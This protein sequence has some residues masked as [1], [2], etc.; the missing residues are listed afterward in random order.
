VDIGYHYQPKWTTWSAETP[1]TIADASDADPTPPTGAS[2]FYKRAFFG[3]PCQ[4]THTTNLFDWGTVLCAYVRS[5]TYQYDPHSNT[6]Y[7]HC[8]IEIKKSLDSGR[9]WQWI[10][11][12][13]CV[14]DPTW[15]DNDDCYL[16][17]R[18]TE[19]WTDVQDNTIQV[20]DPFLIQLSNGDLLCS[21]RQW[22]YG[23]VSY[24]EDGS[25][26]EWED[27]RIR[28]CKL[29][30]DGYNWT[31]PC[32]IQQD[33]PPTCDWG[34][35]FSK[36]SWIV[37]DSTLLERAD[38]KVICFFSRQPNKVV[39][40]VNL[41][42]PVESQEPWPAG[43]DDYLQA[44]PYHWVMPYGAA[45]IITNLDTMSLYPSLESPRQAPIIVCCRPDPVTN[46]WVLG[47]YP[48]NVTGYS[49]PWPL[50]QTGM[51]NGVL[52]S[53]GAVRVVF[54]DTLEDPYT[55]YPLRVSAA[56]A[57]DSDGKVWERPSDYD[58]VF[59]P[60]PGQTVRSAGA[61]NL[62]RVSDGTLICCFTTDED[63]GLAGT[64]PDYPAYSN[65][66]AVYSSSDGETWSDRSVQVVPIR[67]DP[68]NTK[69][70]AS[71]SGLCR[72][73]DDSLLCVFSEG[74][75]DDSHIYLSPDFRSLMCT[76]STDW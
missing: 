36:W 11:Q 20:A 5:Y 3:R 31:E 47:S 69:R 51:C 23:S 43:L 70:F 74:P 57:W 52:F 4:I 66:K 27:F 53:N 63:S 72:L 71:W 38:H 37:S 14:Y 49:D 61:P 15:G 65:I 6:Y 42:G 54:E 40:T 30:H 35:R 8:C 60:D 26:W 59:D 29:A 1:A 2:F 17:D 75:Y 22:T 34:D 9:T 64:G 55:Y 32:D 24:G 68:I 10:G 41:E 45:R 62:A 18:V 46:N 39:H 7:D 12:F 13:R 56:F 28:V 21:F 44:D 16:W 48:D 67:F 76:R 33:S 58:L 19:E 73:S 25:R 50:W